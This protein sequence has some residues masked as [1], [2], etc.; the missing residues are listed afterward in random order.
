MPIMHKKSPLKQVG[1]E[2]LMTY[3]NANSE[4]LAIKGMK[5]NKNKEIELPIQVMIV[6]D[7]KLK[8]VF[9]SE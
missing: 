8:E 6:K 2:D 3:I 7:G 5:Y 4:K 9:V 1:I